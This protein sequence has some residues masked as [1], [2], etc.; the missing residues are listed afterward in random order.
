M[1][2]LIAMLLAL[3]MVLSLAACNQ[4]EQPKGT[5][6][7]K[8]TNP[9]AT[10]APTDPPSWQVEHPTWLCEEKTTLSVYTKE[11][12]SASAYMNNDQFF[13]Q[14]LEEYT[15]VHIEWVTVPGTDY[16]TS[17]STKL[18]SGEKLTD[19]IL[20]NNVN[21]AQDAG[22][23]EQIIDLAP[24]WEAGLFSNIQAYY[25]DGGATYK[26]MATNAEGAMYA[27]GGQGSPD[28]ND[29]ILYFNTDWMKQ[30]NL[31]IPTTLDELTH[32][33]RTMKAAGDLN[34]NGQDDEIILTSSSLN[35]FLA[36]IASAF[37]IEW[38]EDSLPNWSAG[39]DG[40]VYN[41]YTT[42]NMK[43]MMEWL[44]TMYAEGI[45]DPELNTNKIKVVNEKVATDRVG[46][47][48]MY[49]TYSTTWGN[50]TPD[51]LEN[52]YSEQFTLGV[53]LKS[54]YNNN[55]P[56]LRRGL[57]GLNRFTGV[58]SDCE[59]PELAA[60]WLDVLL[61][62]PLVI[63][64][65]ICGILGET[66]TKD[67]NGTIT[68]IPNADGQFKP[69][70]FGGGQIELP[71]M[72]VYG[73]TWYSRALLAPWCAEQYD[74]YLASGEWHDPTVMQVKLLTEE[75]KMVYDTYYADFDAAFWEYTEKFLMGQL[76]VAEGWDDYV[77]TLEALGLEDLTGLYQSIHDRTK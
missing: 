17:V 52:P 39:A 26:N 14:W 16:T 53:A 45:I 56:M 12:G 67:A 51:G 6:D 65:R 23:N 63:E 24:Y 4:P 54:Q 1:K 2:K 42:E 69:G 15:N 64:T 25:E 5:T 58:T 62:D 7:P 21:I 77:K 18:A 9:P 41:Q 75:E 34:G 37:G 55:K 36:G 72:A 30:L 76:D 32:V 40:V 10:Q 50:L 60:K 68:I 31:E 20:L 46:A 57:N 44:A 13:W 3:V 29:V 19:I 33:L 28:A 43:A 70:D 59:N 66:Y 49:V 38:A 47:C 27:I 35:Y 71:H 11:G 74:R 61:A 22:Y 73:Q 8:P 48:S